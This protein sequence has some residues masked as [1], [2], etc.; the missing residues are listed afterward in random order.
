MKTVVVV[1]LAVVS[2]GD[3]EGALG[4]EIGGVGVSL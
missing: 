2:K 3:A 4:M 1:E